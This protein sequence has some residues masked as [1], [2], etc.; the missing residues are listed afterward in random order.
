[1]I[2]KY[3]NTVTEIYK[4]LKELKE[5]MMSE[6]YEKMLEEKESYDDETYEAVECMYGDYEVFVEDLK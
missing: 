1:M 3:N 4:N 6:E 5:L 2:E